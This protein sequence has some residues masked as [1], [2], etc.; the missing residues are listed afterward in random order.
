MYVKILVNSNF[1]TVTPL[2]IV[3]ILISSN[4]LA[5]LFLATQDTVCCINT[6]NLRVLMFT[7]ITVF[8]QIPISCNDLASLFLVTR[9]TLFCINTKN[10]ESWGKA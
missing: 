6:K 7:V 5:S 1:I 9:D 3:W 4:H 8:V 10:F 2:V